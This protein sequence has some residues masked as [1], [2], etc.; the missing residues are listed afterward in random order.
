MKNGYLKAATALIVITLLSALAS[1][2][3]GKA[4]RSTE[5][6]QATSQTTD[7]SGTEATGEPETLYYV[8]VGAG[9]EDGSAWANDRGILRIGDDTSHRVTGFKLGDKVILKAEAKEGFE[10]VGWE[11]LWSH[12]P[13]LSTD[14]EYE[15]TVT[16]DMNLMALFAVSTDPNATAVPETPVP[17]TAAPGTEKPEATEEPETLYY[18]DVGAGNEDGSAWANDRGELWIGDDTSHRVTGFKLGEKVIVKAEAK[19]GFKFVG[20][21]ILWSHGPI[22]ST[23]NEYEITV[24]G[25][26]NLMALFAVDS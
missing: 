21:V 2:G 10:F 7:D 22:L 18:V 13:I 9:N 23:D 14:N 6:P 4:E 12:G 25:N 17:E 5:A 24:T 19:E 20:W 16:G 3:T 26:M 11:I 8:D 1:C 15:I